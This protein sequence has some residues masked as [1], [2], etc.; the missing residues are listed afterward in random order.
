MFGPYF[1]KRE[2]EMNRLLRLLLVC[3]FLVVLSAAR[4]AAAPSPAMQCGEYE[5]Q[6]D[7]GTGIFACFE[8]GDE[9]CDVDLCRFTCWAQCI[10]WDGGDSSWFCED[11]E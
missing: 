8:N 9:I 4:P 11:G 2:M 7:W 5:C 10:V 3:T 1:S 6:N